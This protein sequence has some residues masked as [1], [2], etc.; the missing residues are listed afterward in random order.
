MKI[1]GDILP[2]L[3][4]MFGGGGGQKIILDLTDEVLDAIAERM[5]KKIKDEFFVSSGTSGVVGSAVDNDE[6]PIYLRN[7]PKPFVHDDE[8][9]GRV[10]P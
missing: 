7:I 4:S 8:D 5:A 10:K 2:T 3:S 6:P 9:V 1:H